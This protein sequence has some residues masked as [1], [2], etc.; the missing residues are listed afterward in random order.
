[1]HGSSPLSS[2][3]AARADRSGARPTGDERPPLK[4]SADGVRRQPKESRRVV[5]CCDQG[6]PAE[7]LRDA[8]RVGSALTAEGHSVAYLVGDPVTFVEHAGSWTPRELYQAPVLRSAPQL[9]MKRPSVDS[10]ADLMATV[11][12]DDKKTLITL[13]SLSNAELAALRPDAVIGFLTPV[14][15]LVGPAHAPTFALG[16]GYALPPVLG[17]SFPRLSV[18]STPLGDEELMLSNANAVL[19]R[20]GK[21]SLAALSE[22]VSR[23]TCVLYGL[24]YFD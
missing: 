22:V 23:C 12:F 9:L 5:I 4:E 10:L 13:A 14:L 7:L 16:N 6:A 20:L 1:M 8:L 17:T 18:D 11:G 2:E 15:W 21:P 24:P 3:Q 19:A